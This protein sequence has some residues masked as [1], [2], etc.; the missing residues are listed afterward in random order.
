MDHAV[1][2]A[3]VTVWAGVA[4][5]YQSNWPLGFFV[6]VIGA[7]FFLVGRAYAAARRRRGSTATTA[8]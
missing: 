2:I 1:A 6:G 8:A 3:L 7:A 4:L 5:S